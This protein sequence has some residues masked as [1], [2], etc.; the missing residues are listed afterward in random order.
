[1]PILRSGELDIIS[2]SNE[3]TKRLG[4]RLGNL[5]QAGDVICLSGD[6]GAGKTVF[7]SGIGDGWGSRY[8]VTSPTYTLVH[9]HQRLH[10][11]TLLYHLDCYRMVHVDEVDSIGF[12]DLLDGN[13]IL[14]IEWADR[15]ESALPKERL[16][17][18][19]HV[20]AETR[21][22]F[23]LEAKGERYQQIVAAFRKSI[24]GA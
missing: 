16:W 20:F 21:R 10:D 17:I 14:L 4:L 18:D 11:E 15:I 12:D 1:M 19:I 13:H 24:F 9:Q 3:Q 6:M 7:A 2:R 23:I 5:L 8:K 22:N